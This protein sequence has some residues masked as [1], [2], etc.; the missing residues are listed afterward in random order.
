[1]AGGALLVCVAAAL[2]I[3]GPS[4]VSPSVSVPRDVGVARAANT[5][6]ILQGTGKKLPKYGVRDPL[7][8][9][10]SIRTGL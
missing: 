9:G 8:K 10:M 6:T 3:A 7:P 1:M 2:L 5:E 4:F